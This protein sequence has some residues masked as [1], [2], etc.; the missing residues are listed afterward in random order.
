MLFDWIELLCVPF[1]VLIRDLILVVKL[2]FLMGTTYF[3]LSFILQTSFSHFLIVC[4]SGKNAKSLW[5]LN[6]SFG[7]FTS[8][9]RKYPLFLF[10]S[11]FLM[12]RSLNFNNLFTHL[13]PFTGNFWDIA[14]P[15]KLFA[16]KYMRYDD[17]ILLPQFFIYLLFALAYLYTA[18]HVPPRIPFSTIS[19]ISISVSNSNFT[20]VFFKQAC[21]ANLGAVKKWAGSSS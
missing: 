5:R 18:W 1:L 17:M 9:S 14:H 7:Y 13:K 4:Y 21:H 12:K 10:S 11:Y 6:K 19:S 20:P 15:Y 2:L 3:S 16:S 8:T